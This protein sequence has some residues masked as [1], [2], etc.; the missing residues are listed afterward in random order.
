MP[1][2]PGIQPIGRP[3]SARAAAVVLPLVVAAV[4][5][6]FRDDVTNATSVL[7]LVLVVVGAAS[8]G[9]RPTGLLAAVSSGVWFDFFLVPPFHTFTIDNRDDIETAVLLVLISGAVTEVAL[10]GR[11]QQAR[12]SRRSGYLEGL[13]NAA[14]AVAEGTAPDSAVTDLVAGQITE[15]LDADEGHFVK[16]PVHD[17]R[18]A[19][20]DH[21]GVLVRD[22]RPVDVDRVGLPTDEYTAVPVRKGPHEVGHF[23]LTAASRVAY[24]SREQRR[25]A[26]LLADQVAAVDVLR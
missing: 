8:T 14:R 18:V 16:G 7:I 10:W 4:L 19:V 2:R 5:G 25:V 23:L 15:V 3:S 11:R 12:A 20:L 17:S 1:A 13:L 21:D 26:V 22:G 24:P 9:D 6:A